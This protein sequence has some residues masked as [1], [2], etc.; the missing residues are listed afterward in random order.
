M[1][2]MYCAIL[3]SDILRL[4][5]SPSR[6]L[7]FPRNDAFRY[8][9]YITHSRIHQTIIIVKRPLQHSPWRSSWTNAYLANSV[10][11]SRFPV[12]PRWRL[13]L[14]HRRNV[15]KPSFRKIPHK[16]PFYD[17]LRIALNNIYRVPCESVYWLWILV[18]TKQIG[19]AP[20]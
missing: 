18:R 19:L 6:L 13:V 10:I 11:C 5:L 14:K 4:T 2:L 9:A 3:K 12:K 20:L 16:T 15:G 7:L 17:T 1:S 8:I